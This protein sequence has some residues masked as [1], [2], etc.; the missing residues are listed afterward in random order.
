MNSDE[1]KL[2]QGIDNGIITQEQANRLLVLW[3]QEA[4]AESVSGESGAPMSKFLYYLGAM[5][6]IG[7]MSW[8][9][10]TA[11][12]IFRGFGLFAIAAGYAAVFCW[13]ARYF[14]QKST[15]LSG[16]FVVMAVCMTPLGVFGLQAGLNIWPYEEP[17]AY[18]S[19]YLYVRGGW[20]MMEI[21]TIATGIF[22]LRYSRI[23]FAMAPIAFTL[24]FMSMDITPIIAGTDYNG[25]VRKQVSIVFGLVMLGIALAV[26]RQQQIDY[27]KWLFIFGAIA[28]WG[29][30]SLLQSESELSKF[31][32]C[33]INVAMMFCGVLL[34]RKVLMV[35]G[36]IGFF[37]YLGYLSWSVFQNSIVFPFSLTVLGLAVVYLGWVYHKKYDAIQRHVRKSMPQFILELLPGVRQVGNDANNKP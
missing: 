18:K 7:A 27:A 31:I 32:Y 35:F 16:L 3:R 29:G 19:F 23:P 14:K 10:N 28:F 34:N 5:I 12:D 17:G 8:L 9:M 24:W 20:F 37:G 26:E 6:V 33:L 30:L 2:I 22:S 13:L 21:A 4:P 11:W 25:D 36:G 15:V 1:Q